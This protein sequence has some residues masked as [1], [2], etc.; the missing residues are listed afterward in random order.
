MKT[1]LIL[2]LI[3]FA[4]IGCN[5]AHYEGSLDAWQIRRIGKCQYLYRFND[6]MAHKGDCDNPIHPE[7]WPNK[8]IFLEKE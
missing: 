8:P 3:I 7:N 2:S 6:Q 1:K 4:L 5:D